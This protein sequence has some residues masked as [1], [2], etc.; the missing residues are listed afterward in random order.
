M[1]RS[2]KEKFKVQV[3]MK[4]KFEIENENVKNI[5]KFKIRKIW[6]DRNVMSVSVS[7]I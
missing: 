3:N 5:K 2:L 7:L 6:M 4:M 1:N